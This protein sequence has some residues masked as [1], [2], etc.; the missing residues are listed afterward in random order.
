MPAQ[1]HLATLIDADP[2]PV[3]QIER[4]TGL[5]EGSISY[6]TRPSTADRTQRLPKLNVM[7]YIAKALDKPLEVV[8]QACIRD[9]GIS[10][11]PAFTPAEVDL[12]HRIRAL[13]EADQQRIKDIVASFERHPHPQ[14]APPQPSKR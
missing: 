4:D 11:E 9:L 5:P 7:E 14:P 1:T 8:T 13:P 12:M 2:R 6:Y 10:I 3:R